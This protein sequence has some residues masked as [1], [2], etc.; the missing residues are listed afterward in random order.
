L[1]EATWIKQ[2]MQKNRRRKNNERVSHISTVLFL[3]FVSLFVLLPVRGETLILHLKNGDR[4]T[5]SLLS[6]STNA[7]TL[8]SPV[9]GSIKIPPGQISKREVLADTVGTNATVVANATNASATAAAPATNALAAATPKPP[10]APANPEATPMASLPHYWKHDLQFGL[11]LRYAEVDSQEFLLIEKSTYTKPPFRHLFEVNFKYGHSADALSE[12][13]L[14]G[15]EKTEYQ[16]TPKTYLFN[17]VDAGYDEI[18]KIDFQ[19]DFGPGV[20]VELLKLTNFVWKTETGFNFE[21]QYRSDNSVETSY[22][23][24][25]AEIFAWRMWEK[26]TA[27]AKFEVFPNLGRLGE[28]RLRIESTL[29]YPV[30]NRLSL[31]LNVVDLHDTQPAQGVDPNDLQIRST[32]GVTF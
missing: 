9:F 13:S 29:R 24:R 23:I 3:L 18:R 10:M 21:Q 6:E 5:G 15:R 19:Y 30:S 8:T 17:I 31:N 32:I 25:I 11:N 2:R 16:L 28:Y 27:D 7:V 14:T 22:A 20:G 12:N 1:T 26:L 4:I